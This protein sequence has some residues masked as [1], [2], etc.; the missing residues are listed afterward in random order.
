MAKLTIRDLALIGEIDQLVASE[1]A[2]HP[3]RRISREGWARERLYEALR[4]RRP[5]PRSARRASEAK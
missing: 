5:R 3:G 4:A 2:R 1:K